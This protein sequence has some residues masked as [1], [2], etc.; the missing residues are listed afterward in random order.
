MHFFAWTG[1]DPL[2]NFIIGLSSQRFYHIFLPFPSLLVWNLI[3][4]KAIGS[5]QEA[6]VRV[7][8]VVNTFHPLFCLVVLSF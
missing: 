8:Q 6:P 7:S 4:V 5:P 3:I 2:L 1:V